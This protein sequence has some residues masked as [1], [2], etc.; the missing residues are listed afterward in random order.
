ME[1]TIIPLTYLI[2]LILN[3]YKRKHY[4]LKYAGYDLVTGTRTTVSLNLI[5]SA[6]IKLHSYI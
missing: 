6:Q 2:S 3:D 5:I 1:Q 4:D